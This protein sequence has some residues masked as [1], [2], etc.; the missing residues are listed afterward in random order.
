MSSKW[1]WIFGI[2]TASGFVLA[3]LFWEVTQDV[4]GRDVAAVAIGFA[5]GATTAALI[6]TFVFHAPPRPSGE[7]DAGANLP[8]ETGKPAPARI[9]SVSIPG[10]TEHGKLTADW[11]MHTGSHLVRW[12]SNKQV[13]ER[14][15][16]AEE[17]EGWVVLYGNN[18]QQDRFTSPEGER[19][20][21]AESLKQGMAMMEGRT[22]RMN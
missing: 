12:K 21:A 2:L 16:P 14:L 1:S 19:L 13:T 7:P 20:G 17:G 22:S 4:S 11:N 15:D 6:A 18:L 9:P 10:R 5:L 8:P 3:F